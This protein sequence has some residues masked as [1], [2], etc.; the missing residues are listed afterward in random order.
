[1]M[2]EIVLDTETTGLNYKAGDRIIE[3]GCVELINHVSTT[4][5]LQFYCST[6]KIIDESA[7]KIHGLTNA[8]LN[9][10][11]PFKE[12]VKKFLAFIGNDPLIIHN[13]EFD[14][15]FINNELML[16]GI[17]P[18]KNK[19]IDTVS[20]ARKKLNTRIANLDY[21]CRRFQIDLSERNLHGALL[22]SQLLAE[23]YLELMGG[24]QISMNLNIT[25]ENK[26]LPS[27]NNIKKTYLFSR[28]VLNNKDTLLHKSMVRGIKDSLWKKFDY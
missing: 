18:L 15:G 23:V 4:N 14:L 12:Y 20:F 22:D 19:I 2:R 11:P 21:L 17:E 6:N 16:L 1:M 13:A 3:V 25:K 28:I 10:Y 7:I 5:N 8:F 9:E 27:K 26:N 24:K